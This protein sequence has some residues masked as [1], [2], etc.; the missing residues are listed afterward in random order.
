MSE[1]LQIQIV[2][3]RQQGVRAE[4]ASHHAGITKRSRLAKSGGR[5]AWWTS[6]PLQGWKRTAR[7]GWV[8]LLPLCSKHARK[9]LQ[10]LLCAKH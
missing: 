1:I 5:M 8:T 7:G 4:Q 6:A 2:H 9:R 3:C 10:E